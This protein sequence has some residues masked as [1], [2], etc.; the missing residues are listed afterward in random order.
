M[1]GVPEDRTGEAVK[2]WCCGGCWWMRNG[3]RHEWGP[4]ETVCTRGT[5]VSKASPPVL[6]G[7]GR[8]RRE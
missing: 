8:V 3:G 4:N 7:S 2:A 1:I 6:W 5:L